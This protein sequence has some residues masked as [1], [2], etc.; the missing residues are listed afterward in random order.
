MRKVYVILLF[1]A[2]VQLANAQ[3]LQWSGS[4]MLDTS[5]A[6]DLSEYEI[7]DVNKVGDCYTLKWGR[8]G[9]GEPTEWGINTV[10]CMKEGKLDLIVL[11][12]GEQYKLTADLVNGEMVDAVMASG[13][14]DSFLFERVYE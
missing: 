8:G 3:E 12:N 11:R 2:L 7:I 9:M 4:Y 14:D 10:C 1:L 6:N 13:P 5:G